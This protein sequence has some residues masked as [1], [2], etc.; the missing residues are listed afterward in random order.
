MVLQD[1]G[2]FKRIVTLNNLKKLISCSTIFFSIEG[3]LILIKIVASLLREE[4]RLNPRS[5]HWHFTQRVRS[6]FT[7]R[8]LLQHHQLSMMKSWSLKRLAWL[9]RQRSSLSWGFTI[10]T[11]ERLFSIQVL[12]R[13][14]EGHLRIRRRTRG[15]QRERQ[16]LSLRSKA[17]RM[18]WAAKRT[19]KLWGTV[20]RWRRRIW[21]Q[22][23]RAL[24]LLKSTRW[25]SQDKW[26]QVY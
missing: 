16:E 2:R 15:T 3:F 12:H 25:P 26:M 13:W 5:M 10:T 9:R 24:S 20:F 11:I 7:P 6:T 17:M 14:K 8:R 1:H 4:W 22:Q 19:G 21:R 23:P 18:G